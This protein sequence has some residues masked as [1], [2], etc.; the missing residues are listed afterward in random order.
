MFSRVSV[1]VMKK[2][3][4]TTN[5]RGRGGP[6]RHRATVEQ[7][8]V[9]NVYVYYNS[10]IARIILSEKYVIAYEKWTARIIY[11]G[12]LALSCFLILREKRKAAKKAEHKNSIQQ[13]RQDKRIALPCLTGTMSGEDD[14]SRTS[15]VL[16]TN[17]ECS[18]DITQWS[19]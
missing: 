11:E 10:D 4:R 1:S 18:I 5:K 16:K 9:I 3:Q 19:L 13:R 2:Q 12:C 7:P 6:G 17:T 15:G 8:C 14:D